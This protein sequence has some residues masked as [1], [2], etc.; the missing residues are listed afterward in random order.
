MT[1]KNPFLAQLLDGDYNN[2]YLVSVSFHPT[3]FEPLS[4]EISIFL[5]ETNFN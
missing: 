2:N 1:P 3:S 5:N 4:G